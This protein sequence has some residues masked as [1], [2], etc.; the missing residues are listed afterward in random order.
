MKKGLLLFSTLLAVVLLTGCSGS[1]TRL[2]C[3]QTVSGVNV[4]MLADFKSD[5]LTYLGLQ[6]DMDLSAYSDSQ[7]NLLKDQDMCSSV[8]ASM[9]GYTNAF[10][11]CKQNIENKNL[12]ITA[13]FDLDKLTDGLSRKTNIEEAKVQLE[14]QGYSCVTSNK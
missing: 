1:V 10:T 6:Y 7:I 5:E 13:D 11:N 14:K 4:K 9:A 12:K 8:K 2:T 3:S